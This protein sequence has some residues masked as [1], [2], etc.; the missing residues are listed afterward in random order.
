LLLYTEVVYKQFGSVDWLLDNR[1]YFTIL[2]SYYG[3]HKSFALQLD[4][5]CSFITGNEPT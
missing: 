3:S 1:L 4:S 5:S 2:M